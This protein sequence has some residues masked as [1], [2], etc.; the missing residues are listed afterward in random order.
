VVS[1]AGESSVIHSLPKLEGPTGFAFQPAGAVELYVDG[2]RLLGK[3]SLKVLT[4]AE[5]SALIE[6]AGAYEVP[7]IQ[8]LLM[9]IDVARS[10]FRKMEARLQRLRSVISVLA[11]IPIALALVALCA[12]LA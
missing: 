10:E 8:K 3:T 9:E 6:F 2:S 11:G 7:E 12:W 5:L 1:K 4:R